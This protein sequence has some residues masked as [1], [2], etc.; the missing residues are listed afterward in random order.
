MEDINMNTNNL[1]QEAPT[2]ERIDVDFVSLKSD[3]EYLV[4]AGGGVRGFWS[5]GVLIGLEE[6][7]IMNNIK[8]IAGTSVGAIIGAL[9]ALGY[10]PRELAS[11]MCSIPL[12]LYFGKM[13]V[14]KILSKGYNSE[15]D[16][17]KQIIKG[18]IKEKCGKSNMTL[19]EVYEKSKK[20]LHILTICKETRKT[21]ILN[22]KTFP[23]LPLERAVRMSMALPLIFKPVRW[24]GKHYL[25]SGCRVNYPMHIFPLD[26]TLGI[27]PATRGASKDFQHDKI[28]T[29]SNLLDLLGNIK[30]TLNMIIDLLFF[31]FKCLS[32]EVEERMLQGKSFF[33]I[34]GETG[35]KTLDFDI[36][37]M[38]K[39]DLVVKG[40]ADIH[41]YLKKPF[42]KKLIIE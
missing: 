42:A 36:S 17:I 40:Q 5:A 18:I 19:A 37:S 41:E 2:F 15:W 25:D 23:D 7:G 38:K 6:A 39:V 31:V 4:L 24:K 9:W 26:K 35:V 12:G 20:E 21:V 34:E 30:N 13:D 14:T 3:I 28:H 22:H 10:S 11:K 27:R 29:P 1:S 16:G 32:D 33:E 8:G